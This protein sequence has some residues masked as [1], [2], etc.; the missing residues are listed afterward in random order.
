MSSHTRHEMPKK[1]AKLLAPKKSSRAQLVVKFGDKTAK[2]GNSSA[3][4]EEGLFRLDGMLWQ[5]E[6][7]I[8]DKLFSVPDDDTD[9]GSAN[10]NDI[11]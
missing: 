5:Q 1:V 11:N 8:Y 6:M 4:S 3:G 7:R 10:G 9:I 2:F